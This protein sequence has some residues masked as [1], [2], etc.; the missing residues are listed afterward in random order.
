MGLKGDGCTASPV[1]LRAKLHEGLGFGVEPG[2]IAVHDCLPDDSEGCFGPEVVFVVELVDHLHY[3]LGWQAGILDV[4]HL[5]ASLIGHGSV[6]DE[7][8]CLRIVEELSARE[9]VSDRDLNRLAIK[10][11]RKFD[12]VADRFS[13]LSGKAEDEVAVD[14]E[15]KFVAIARKV[16]RTLHGGPLPDVLED[17][18]VAGFV[19]DN[20]QAAARVLH[21]L[22]GLVIGGD[23][24]I[25]G[26]GEA[27]GFQLLAEFDGAEFLDVEG[28][29]VEEE[30][31]DV[32]EELFGVGQFG[33]HVVCRSLAPGVA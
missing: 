29:V 30:L 5:M 19:P 24:R 2:N 31:F 8:I 33:G 3:I 4:C 10:P 1:P 21:G 14:D 25:A 22:E 7:S 6:G 23:T 12:G 20:K 11:F 32:R 17:L 27:K 9:G 13:G 18:R 26:P 15:A 16:Q 28:I